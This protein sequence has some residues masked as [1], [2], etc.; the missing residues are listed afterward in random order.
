M[1]DIGDSVER[2]HARGVTDGLPAEPPT[3][4]RPR[5]AIATS[6]RSGDDWGSRWPQPFARGAEDR[7]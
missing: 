6:G 7:G 3:L 5:A 4:A 2:L 1:A